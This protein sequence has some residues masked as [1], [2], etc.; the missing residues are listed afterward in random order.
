MEKKSKKM[1]EAGIV[2]QDCGSFKTITEV[3]NGFLV[4]SVLSNFDDTI[5]GV[6]ESQAL[7][8]RLTGRV[9]RSLIEQA[10]DV[11]D[12]RV[13]EKKGRRLEVNLYMLDENTKEIFNKV[14]AVL[15]DFA[16]IKD[17]VVLPESEDELSCLVSMLAKSIK[18]GEVI[19]LVT[20]VCPDWSRDKEGRY[21]FKSLG[22]GD[23]FIANKFFVNSPEILSALKRSEVPFKGVI[24]FADW[25]LET[26]IDAKDT[27]GQ[28]LSPEDIQMCFASTFARI[29]Q[30]LTVLQNDPNLGGLFAD[31][32]V[33]SMKEFLAKRIDEVEVMK[34]MRH[35]FTTDKQGLR[36]LEVLNRDSF[37]L[38]R[39]RLS[40][41]EEEN[42]ELTL[43]NLVEYSTVGSSVGD[44]SMLIVCESRTTSRCYNLPRERDK[45]VPVF[46]V[47]GREALTSGVNIL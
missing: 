11:C 17:T 2:N 14:G 44:M 12:V 7:L 16:K 30:A 35:F 27:F 37:K 36:L 31:F 5:M 38:N 28:K 26:E 9:V 46:Y 25:G 19:T 45:K 39:Q 18:T 43:R 22:G 8:N 33:V 47:K 10:V 3:R 15:S 1:I 24:L 13:T 21:D 4:E 42:Q 20:P 23:S 32:K 40:V 34:R 41:K 6:F 29:D